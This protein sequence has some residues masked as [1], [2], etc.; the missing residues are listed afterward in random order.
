MAGEYLPPV[1]ARL[2]MELAQFT[3]EIARAKAE[4]DSLEQPIEVPITFDA[5]EAMA[6]L[7]NLSAIEGALRATSE[8][9]NEQLRLQEE[10]LLSKAG[11]ASLL[12][13]ALRQVVD[14]EIAL[15]EI[16][17]RARDAATEEAF[18]LDALVGGASRL[19]AAEEGLTVASATAD[20]TLTRQTRTVESKT[21]M[22]DRL[23]EAARLA[24]EEE[25]HIRDVA[26]ECGVTLEDQ[27]VKTATKADKLRAMAIAAI[28]AQ[29]QEIKLT[30]LADLAGISLE[31]QGN[32][33][34]TKAQ[35]LEVLANRLADAADEEERL[36]IAAE[37]A[38]L[39]MDHQARS[40][41][42]AAAA[43]AGAA[44]AGRAVTPGGLWGLG[45]TVTLFQGMAGLEHQIGIWHLLLDGAIEAFITL[46][47]S[48]LDLGLAA[49]AMMPTFIEIGD[50]MSA[51]RDVTK[52]LGGTMSGA[53]GTIDSFTRSVA[54]L[55]VEAFGGV[56][57][58]FT[59]GGGQMEQVIR[60]VIVGFD[61][62]IAKLDIFFARVGGLGVLT[63]GLGFLHQFEGVVNTLGVAMAN[64]FKEDPGTAHYLLDLVQIGARAV[65]IF[66]EL[67][68]PIVEATIALHA[69]WLYGGLL[70]TVLGRIPLLGAAL[71]GIIGAFLQ[72]AIALLV[73]FL[74][75]IP[76]I[77]PLFEAAFAGLA[78]ELL[79]VNM[80]VVGIA[81][82]AL[83]AYA[84]AKGWDSASAS[85]TNY[86]NAQNKALSNMSASQAFNQ[87]PKDIQALNA[88]IAN[89][90]VAKIQS[91]WNALGNTGNAFSKD[92]KAD[93]SDWA[94][95][96]KAFSNPSVSSD[97]LGKFGNA[98][99]GI[100]V[101]GQGAAV[102]AQ[103]DM[104]AY[105]MQIQALSKDQVNLYGTMGNLVRQGFSTQQSFALMS[106]AGVQAGDTFA[107]MNQKVNNLIAGYKAMGVQG[108]L[109]QNSMNAVNFSTWLGDSNIAAVTGG[110][111]TFI[112]TV[113]GGIT[114][115][116]TFQQ[117]LITFHT[118]ATAA[119]A[120]MTGLSANSLTLQ[121]DFS[122]NVT[123][124]SAMINSLYT[125]A[126]VSKQGATGTRD[127]TQATK[128]MIALTLPAVGGNKALQSSLLALAQQGGAPAFT[129]MKQ[130]AQW[131]GNVKNP[132]QQLEA[133][134]TSMTGASSNLARDVQNLASALN[135]DMTQAM[136]QAIVAA[137]GGTKSLENW[138][139]S[140]LNG[141]HNMS[142][143]ASQ[144]KA[145][146][147]SLI[148]V[149]GNTAAAK[150]QF[151]AFNQMLG[152]SK[153]VSDQLWQALT[154]RSSSAA[155]AIASAMGR[156]QA[157]IDSLH[158]KTITIATDYVNYG[159]PPGGSAPM[160]HRG[161]QAG[162]ASGTS[163]APSGWAWVG[164]AGPELV[165]FS[166][167]ERVLNNAQSS[168]TGGDAVHEVHVFLDGKKIYQA[169]QGEALKK[170]RTTGTNGLS[171]RTR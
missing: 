46:G 163:S 118:A 8:R 131:V 137:S 151:E 166:G 33:S 96:F 41:T 165:N 62:W 86:I 81:V 144:G 29:I 80:I 66:T 25:A 105:R 69:L 44:A 15:T 22:L 160:V 90:N 27:G 3:E 138:A 123:N 154:S 127:I 53:S 100:F 167:G 37:A 145:V 61:D 72:T 93:M 77:G 26:A 101:P 108:T 143:F 42:S 133:I 92:T 136:D 146:V 104:Q 55:A 39:M 110:W 94:A 45:G 113:T 13:D 122:S 40:A 1:V 162:F 103:T 155:S 164:E 19:G 31:E 158:G 57:T 75:M 149:Y 153:S 114:A 16:A 4:L 21:E 121:Q 49:G 150:T 23:A 116:Q 36:A 11:R 85:V 168:A 59:R 147:K 106:M 83:G 63:A 24:A 9:A 74:E 50:R 142:Q 115:F 148:D 171:K 5:E 130:L 124:A 139:N 120:S 67:P 17:G 14:E 119:G 70:L 91:T 48:I 79:M 156:A 76:L 95:A 97:L 135:P 12:A 99:K 20:T 60:E 82:L 129:S 125:L 87:I 68:K 159:T 98:I 112:S 64:L 35:K 56:F 65:Q 43:T 109:M 157:A 141:N 128:D 30:Q 47:T 132:A 140:V 58:M 54:P 88:Q 7:T 152:I 6:E 18:S 111:T 28:E 10:A 32:K 51:L 73:N 38:A 126:A 117:G 71:S 170:Q 102:Q 2:T 107:L 34:L 78:P 52:S 161:A 84:L 134:M 89:V 169:M